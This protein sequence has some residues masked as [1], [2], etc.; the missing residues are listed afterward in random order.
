MQ[1]GMS[2]VEEKRIRRNR[3]PQRTR[4]QSPRKGAKAGAAPDNEKTDW[5]KK[6]RGKVA[7]KEESQPN[8]N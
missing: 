8:T 7:S 5:W 6:A 2:D 1:M 3:G 4:A